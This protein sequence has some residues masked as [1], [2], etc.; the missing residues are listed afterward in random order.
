[1]PPSRGQWVSPEGELFT[2]RMIPVR[3]MATDAEAEGIADYTASYYEQRAVMFYK[4]SSDVRIKN[5]EGV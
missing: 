4:V 3:F 1:M 2:E 5:Y